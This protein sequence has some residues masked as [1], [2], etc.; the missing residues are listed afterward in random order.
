MNSAQNQ[1]LINLIR[2]VQREKHR[3]KWNLH[4]TNDIINVIKIKFLQNKEWK[5]R[6][7]IKSCKVI[8]FLFAVFFFSTCFCMQTVYDCLQTV[9]DGLQ[10]KKVLSVRLENDLYTKVNKH[11]L[12]N[13][14]L[15]S[16]SLNQYFR[17]KEPNKKIDADFSNNSDYISLLKESIDEKTNILVFYKKK[18][19]I[20]RLCQ[21][22][23]FLFLNV[24]RWNYL[25]KNLNKSIELNT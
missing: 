2:L 13:A 4:V 10:M 19:N 23:K 22:L 25:T 9:C 3:K 16:K 12:N 20:L 17:S 21:W 15:V 6:F 18:L 8:K 7:T 11:D 24:L 1:A 5:L 14:V